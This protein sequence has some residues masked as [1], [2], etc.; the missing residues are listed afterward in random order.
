MVVERGECFATVNGI[1][2]HTVQDL[3][4][5]TVAALVRSNKGPIIIIMHQYAYLGKGKTI[6]SSVQ[7]KYYKNNV[8]DKSSKVGG[9]QRIVTLDGYI[10]PLNI[11]NGLAYMDM[12]MPTDK[13]FSTL[14]HVVLTSDSNWDPTILDSEFDPEVEWQDAQ[15]DD[16]FDPNFDDT[17]NYLHRQI[18]FL[19]TFSSVEEQEDFDDKVDRLLLHVNRNKVKMKEP[20]YEAL[21][22]CFAWAPADIVK[23]MLEAT[24]Q[25]AQNSYNL[26]FRMHYC[27]HFPALN[28][29]CHR[30]AV[31]TDTIYSD[32]PAIDD[33]ATCAQI[34]VG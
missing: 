32:T 8:D 11:R 21:C 1:D 16:F 4:I 14:P 7:I 33:G 15:E 12:S 30:E 2:G 24:T 26:P 31:A 27:L 23:K 18:A 25:C 9:K 17:G 5:C 22:P 29:D 20:D 6:H 19:D 28:V 10:I 13:E 3:P 34:F